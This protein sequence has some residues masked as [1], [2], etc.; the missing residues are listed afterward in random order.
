MT[1]DVESGALLLSKPA[2]II[3]ATDAALEIQIALTTMTSQA[4][5]KLTT[6]NDVQ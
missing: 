2:T 3:F 1:Q 6:M 5:T 4:T